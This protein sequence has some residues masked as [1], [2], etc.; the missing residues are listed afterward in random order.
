MIDKSNLAPGSRLQIKHRYIL[1]LAFTIAAAVPV[2]VL[3]SWIERTA[4]SKEI[5]AVWEKHLPIADHTAALLE[6]YAQDV[7]SAFANFAKVHANAARTESAIQSAI[8]V[9][10]RVG[11]R[12]IRILDGRGRV[13]ADVRTESRSGSAFDPAIEAKLRPLLHNRIAYSNV[14][15]D[16]GGHPTIF[17]VQRLDNGG[18]VLAALKPDY[19]IQLQSTISIGEK[20]YA[21]IV[22]NQGAVIAHPISAWRQEMTSLAAIEPVKLMMLRERGVTTYRSPA[23]RQKMIAGYTIVPQTGWGVMIPQ[24]FDELVEKANDVKRIAFIIV[25]CCILAAAVVSWIF[26]GRLTRPLD[27][28]RTTARRI[29]DGKLTSRVPPLPQWAASDLQELADDF[30]E[31]ANRIQNDQKVLATALN[32]AQ[33]ADHAKTQFLANMSHE[34]RTPLNA[35]IGFSETM[36]KQLLGP[37]GNARYSAYAVDIRRS[38]EHLLSII[39]FMLDL[40]KIE[41]GDI[42]VEDD[43]VD[44]AALVRDVH[45]MLGGQAA[46]KRIEFTTELPVRLPQIRG[47]GVKLKQVLLNLV[48]NAV[49]YTLPGGRVAVSAWQDRGGGIAIGVTDDGIGMSKADVTVALIPFGRADHEMVQRINGTGLGLPIAKRFAEIHGGRLEITS[50]RGAGTTVI[51]HLP[52]AR[53]IAA[54]A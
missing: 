34:L 35:I 26:A 45:V 33:S 48:S 53:T 49:K 27:A 13:A 17:L 7:E 18:T 22:D 1:T 36:E 21:V 4:L 28:V 31:M 54:V 11:L 42:E 15:A 20:G 52:P 41:G 3:C 40:S 5:D 38:G 23:D 6:R 2:L 50:E 30:N 32:R 46:E 19:L 10:Q 24:P 16:A 25:L 47:S 12:Q 44:I 51:V 9:A 39:N 43:P 37:I 14:M 8:H 29:A